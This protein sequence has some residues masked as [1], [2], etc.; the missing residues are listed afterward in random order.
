MKT[1]GVILAAGK[2]TRFE[3]NVPKCLMK[4]DEMSILQNNINILKNYCDEI[5]LVISK[6]NRKYF[7]DY[8]KQINILEIKSGLGCGDAVLKT[9]KKINCT[10]LDDRMIL[11]WGDSIQ[12]DIFIKQSLIKY[13]NN[14]LVPAVVEKRPYTL[15]KTDNSLTI[16]KVLFSKYGDNIKKGYHDLSLFIFNINLVYYYLILNYNYFYRNKK[17][18]C[19]K[20]ELIFLDIFNNPL[21]KEGKIVELKRQNAVNSFNTIEEFKKINNEK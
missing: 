20:G 5:Y 6:E 11:C 8:K 2:Q 17:Y 18:I 15:F 7:K 9:I 19:R 10:N 3:L 14:I 4:K 16:K 1:Y 13:N 12:N 21:C